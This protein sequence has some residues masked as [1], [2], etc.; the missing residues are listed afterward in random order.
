[1]LLFG[2]TTNIPLFPFPKN[3]PKNQE[4]ESQKK[5]INKKR[6]I[7]YLG[8]GKLTKREKKI[9]KNQGYVRINILADKR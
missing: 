1:M 9:E 6:L 7:E 5:T 8:L 2:L 4:E 3:F